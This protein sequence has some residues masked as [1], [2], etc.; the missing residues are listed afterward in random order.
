[1]EDSAIKTILVYMKT[2]YDHDHVNDH[3]KR[4]ILVDANDF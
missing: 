3:E 2:V 4:S 1:M